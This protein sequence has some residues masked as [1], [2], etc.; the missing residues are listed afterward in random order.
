MFMKRMGLVV[1]VSSVVGWGAACTIESSECDCLGPDEPT[2]STGGKASGAGGEVGTGGTAS[3]EAGAGGGPD[4][5]GA[6]GEAGCA[7]PELCGN[8]KDDDCDGATDE[9]PC[10]DADACA[11]TGDTSPTDAGWDR[12]FGEAYESAST[13]AVKDGVLHLTDAETDSGSRLVWGKNCFAEF[14]ADSIYVVEA[15]LRAVSA[16]DYL[17]FFIGFGKSSN[18]VE[19]TLDSDSLL[20]GGGTSCD[21]ET[22]NQDLS[23]FVTLRLEL[24]PTGAGSVKTFIDGEEVNSAAPCAAESARSLTFGLGSTTGRGEG[25]LDSLRAWRERR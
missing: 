13:V 19:L 10:R 15:R 22:V 20:I 6:A 8:S 9:T 11:Y 12:L 18:P 3:N 24:D 2:P 17:G 14:E 5:G 25:Y 16:S 23:K 4:A 1:L 7:T 21:S